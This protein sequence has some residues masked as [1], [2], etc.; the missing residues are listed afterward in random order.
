[1]PALVLGPIVRYV[2]SEVATIWLQ[3]DA[4]CEVEILGHRARTWCVDGLHFALVAIEGL[5]PGID[6]PYEVALDGDRSGPS[7]IPRSRP[8]RSVFRPATPSCG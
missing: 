7:R 8:A 3:T 5:T 1:M 6:H 2:D 4:A